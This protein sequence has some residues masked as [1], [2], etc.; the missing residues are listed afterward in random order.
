MGGGSQGSPLAT[1]LLPAFL[2][3]SPAALLARLS[4]LGDFMLLSG[5]AGRQWLVVLALQVLHVQEDQPA[6]C[7]S[8]C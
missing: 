1:H 4:A 5:F 2:L 6:G 8:Q 3:L 7:E